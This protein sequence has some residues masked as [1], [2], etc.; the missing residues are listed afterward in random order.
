[1]IHMVIADDEQIIREGLRDLFPWEE[2][3]I[4]VVFLAANGQEALEYMNDH[5]TALLIADIRMPVMDGLA[6]AQEVRQSHPQVKMILLSAYT[7]F[8]YAR[9]ALRLGVCRYVTKPVDYQELLDTVRQLI[10]ETEHQHSLQPPV[11]Y[12]GY[13]PE[14]AGKISL[15]I[16]ENMAGATLSGAAER[17]G[18]SPNYISQILK[19]VYQETFSQHLLSSRMK[20]ARQLL[21]S[22]S[23]VTDAAN[24]VG[25]ASSRRFHEAFTRYW[26]V[27]PAACRRTK[28]GR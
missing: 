9:R 27:T 6:L 13:Y 23:S 22:G 26:G 14:L 12:Q 18:L 21:E 17:V 5:E 16:Q 24:L 1:M 10:A 4:S 7:D 11:P 8:E 28:G 19:Q 20:E 3:G 15:Y 25:Y 2:L